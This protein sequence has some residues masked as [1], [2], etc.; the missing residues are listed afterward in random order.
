M[1]LLL[2]FKPVSPG[3]DSNW[4]PLKKVVPVSTNKIMAKQRTSTIVI[5]LFPENLK[6]RFLIVLQKY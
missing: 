2:S 1:F 5:V 3:F 6:L 4:P